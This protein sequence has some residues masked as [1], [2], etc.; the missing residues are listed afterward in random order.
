MR[1][2]MWHV[3]GSYSTAFVHGAHEVLVPVL[4]GRGPDG[5]GR[6]QTW[7]WPASAVEVTP[8]EAADAE[9]D[10]VV[11]QRP[12]ELHGLGQEW[13]GGR[14]PGVD[15]PAVYLE[16]NLPQ[17]RIDDMRHPCADVPGIPVVHVSHT[18]ALLWDCGDAPT[19]VVEHG[20]L[21]PGHRYQ[22]DLARTAVVVND[23]VRRG[24]VTGT[25]L[26]PRLREAGPLDLYGMRTEALGGTDL[27]QAGLHDELALRR[28]YAHPVRWTSLGLALLEAM[29][30]GMPVAVLGIGEAAGVVPAEAGV[31]SSD[32][33]VLVAGL[34]RLLADPDAARA[35]GEA[36]R[37]A[38]VE[39]FGLPRFLAAWDDVLMDVAS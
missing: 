36:A 3:H 10:V 20:V 33:D 39:R 8:A 27:P 31:V 37:D 6:A 22:G 4:P 17:G 18:G 32:V 24:R 12:A 15:V 38:V 13:L 21:D 7:E 34:R 11:L 29:H 16:H 28:A 5:R 23:P 14:R 35:A 1:I 25:D 30:L 19:R 2:L 26:L 9:V